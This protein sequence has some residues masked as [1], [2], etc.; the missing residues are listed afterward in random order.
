MECYNN[1]TMYCNYA[2]ALALRNDVKLSGE[3]R[4]VNGVPLVILT[5][6]KL[7]KK[8]IVSKETKDI[9]TTTD[10]SKYYIE[11]DIIIKNID[12][13]IKEDFIC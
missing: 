12:K 4:I 11:I 1:L 13:L 6:E 2:K 7:D 10:M 8:F 3:S 5:F 9:L